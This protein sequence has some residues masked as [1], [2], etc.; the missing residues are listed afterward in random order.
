MNN[1]IKIK[2]IL[3][4]SGFLLAAIGFVIVK[5]IGRDKAREKEWEDIRA[6]YQ[7]RIDSASARLVL[8]QD[9]IK[10]LDTRINEINENLLRNDSALTSNLAELDALRRSY[11]S[12]PVIVRDSM[13][14]EW[15]RTTQPDSS[16]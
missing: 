3:I 9:S 8:Y 7:A 11:R 13:L 4:L 6:F 16:R 10:A 2:Y 12:L 14:L 5:Q 1:C 15:I